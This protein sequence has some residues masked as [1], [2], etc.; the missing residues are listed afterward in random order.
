MYKLFILKYPQYASWYEQIAGSVPPGAEE[1]DVGGMYNQVVV[2]ESV[3]G[4]TDKCNSNDSEN[5]PGS[6]GR[7]KKLENENLAEIDASS[8]SDGNITECDLLVKGAKSGSILEFGARE[9]STVK[10]SVVCNG[11]VCN[12]NYGNGLPEEHTSSHNV[13]NGNTQVST[14]GNDTNRNRILNEEIT[15]KNNSITSAKEPREKTQECFI[16]ENVDKQ[17]HS[18][19]IEKTGLP[20][21][22]GNFSYES[23][24]KKEILISS[25]GDAS[26][27][28][29]PPKSADYITPSIQNTKVLSNDVSV[30]NSELG[31]EGVNHKQEF[32][33]EENCYNS[34]QSQ[35]Q[36]Y[37][38]ANCSED[39]V[40]HQNNSQFDDGN[41]A[42][43]EYSPEYIIAY[44][45]T[46]HQSLS[47][48]I[49]WHIQKEAK[50]W[51]WKNPD[52]DFDISSLDKNLM[53]VV[54]PC[55][56]AGSEYFSEQPM[57]ND[58]TQSE[59]DDLEDNG[60]VVC[61]M[62]SVGS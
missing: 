16:H 42:A 17:R 4:V 50:K 27:L 45:Q 20:A 36:D 51:F 12:L 5:H 35:D 60:K 44:L 21:E 54:F 55:M 61:C 19:C 6:D 11:E 30:K 48:Q 18:K 26:L 15:H 3:A 59:E 43:E 46:E 39:N 8:R 34:S 13:V 56:E 37:S 2:D 40:T 24:D 10:D 38:N 25:A 14:D 53:E 9:S 7:G 32:P 1:I 57:E 29:K 52:K 31:T 47:S 23:K 58:Y 41:E 33:N 49:Y 22:N 62:V 28:I